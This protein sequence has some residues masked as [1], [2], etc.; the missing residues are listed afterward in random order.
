[1]L[2][3]WR[4]KFYSLEAQRT[5][6][7]AGYDRAFMTNLQITTLETHPLW[8]DRTNIETDWP[9]YSVKFYLSGIM[10]IAYSFKRNRIQK[11]LLKS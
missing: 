8:I 6:E 1:M 11:R 3:W 2:G 10:D 7:K 4:R 5:I 9:I